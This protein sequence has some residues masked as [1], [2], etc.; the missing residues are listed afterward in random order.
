MLKHEP[1]NNIMQNERHAKRSHPEQVNPQTKGRLAVPASGE[2]G[3][4]AV[5]L[6]NRDFGEDDNRLMIQVRNRCL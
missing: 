3:G 6:V 5:F 1:L 2:G 4:K